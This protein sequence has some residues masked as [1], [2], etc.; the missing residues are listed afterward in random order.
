[1]NQ[2]AEDVWQIPLT[3][4]NGINAYLVGDVLIDA[5]TRLHG[6]KVVSAVAGRGVA[7]HALTHV[8]I[9]HAGGSKHVKETLG[10]PVWVGADDSEALR[11]GKALPAPNVPGGSL[12]ASAS[13]APKVEPDRE[14]REGDEIGPGFMVL[15]TP[16]HSPGH[17]SYWREADGTLICGDVF[18]NMHILT[19]KYGLH[20]PPRPF[21]YDPPLNRRSERRLAELEPKLVLFGH[22][23]PLRDPGRL[24]EFVA[25][26]PDG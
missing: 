6:A 22:G 21:T 14:L 8:H 20:Q 11:T 17:L 18:F 19:T 23:P 24:K 5:G 25:A 3:P 12:I 4:R 13:G 26:L 1:M 7:A 10:V 9:D 15:E 2:V 16:G